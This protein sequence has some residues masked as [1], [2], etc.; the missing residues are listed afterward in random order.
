MTVFFLFVISCKQTKKVDRGTELYE[1]HCARCHIAPDIDDLPK[2]YWTNYI[3]PEMAA[4]MG[5]KS[6]G[7][8]PYEGMVFEEM[9]IVHNSGIYPYMPILNER[10]WGL[11]KTYILDLAPDSLRIVSHEGDLKK[12]IQFEANTFA[13]DEVPGSFF[14]FLKYQKEGNKFWTGDI[15]GNVLEH[16][17]SDGKTTKLHTVEN[18][19]VDYIE[20]DT[21]AYITDIGILDPSELSTGRIVAAYKNETIKLPDT[22]H[23]PVNNLV[24]DLNNDGIDEMVVSEFGHL[25]GE[26]SMLV[27]NNNGTY[28]KRTLLSQPGTIRTLARDM[29]ADGDLDLIAITSQGDE[30]ITILYQQD[31]LVF[32]TDKAIR[33]SPIYGSSWFEMMDYDGDGDIDIVTVNGDN[34]DKT[35]IQKPYHGLRI[36]LNDGNNKFSEAFFYPLNGATRFVSD[37]FDQDGDFDFAIIST[38]PDYENKPEYSLVYLENKDSGSYQFQTYSFEEAN[39]SRWFLLDKGDIDLDGDMDIILSGFTYVFTP[40]PRSLTVSWGENNADIMVL[41]NR[42]F[43]KKSEE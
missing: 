5:I 31:N 33:F 32:K 7:F 43:H 37:D 30:S 14:T 28:E 36:H 19:V 25:T 10:D 8:K 1:M 2:E 41:E 35:Y 22:L 42:L 16:S 39:L 29:D 20:K 18:A 24:I 12:Q 13:I 4:R 17:F 21:V 34:A 9:E 26:L 23:R 27:R 11:L 38:F 6:E 40:V 15:S 3:L